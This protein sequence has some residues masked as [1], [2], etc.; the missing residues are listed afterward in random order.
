MTGD[1]PRRAAGA[2][3]PDR[4]A[5]MAWVARLSRLANPGMRLALRLPFATPLS[6]R[7]MLVAI[8]GR[9]TGRLYRQPLSYVRDG[10]TLLTPGGGRWKLNLRPD[11]P[12]RARLRGR[13]VRLW[14]ELIGD[15][16]TAAALLARMTAG[17]SAVGRIVPVVGPHGEI[18]RD[19]LDAALRYGFRVVRWHFAAPEAGDS[20]G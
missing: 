20:A 12:V 1:H 11:T 8:R 19:R 6:G 16:D 4:P 13:E 7:L 3:A 10:D 9:R 18:D 5:R 14:P 2:S 17:S 15:A